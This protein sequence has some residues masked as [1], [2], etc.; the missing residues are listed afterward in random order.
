M[1]WTD[2]PAAL[3]DPD[4]FFCDLEVR[5]AAVT[6]PNSPAFAIAFAPTIS[7][8]VMDGLNTL[9]SSLL[10]PTTRQNGTYMS[11]ASATNF[12]AFTL[13]R[14]QCNKAPPPSPP[15]SLKKQ[16]PAPPAPPTQGQALVTFSGVFI[17]QALGVLAGVF[18]WL[19]EKSV[20]KCSEAI[21]TGC[22]KCLR[23]TALERWFK[24][25]MAKRAAKKKKKKDGAGEG[26][27]EGGDEKQKDAGQLNHQDHDNIAAKVVSR[28]QSVMESGATRK[29]DGGGGG[30]GGFA[31]VVHLATSAAA[32]GGR[33]A[34][35]PVDWGLQPQDQVRMLR[36]LVQ[37]MERDLEGGDRGGKEEEDHLDNAG[38]VLSKPQGWRERMR[39]P[40]NPPSGVG[41]GGG[42]EEGALVRLLKPD[43][44]TGE[45]RGEQVGRVAMLR[46]VRT[47]S[48]GR[49]NG[50]SDGE[51]PPTG[52]ASTAVQKLA[53]EP[54]APWTEAERAR[55]DQPPPVSPT[56]SQAQQ[57]RQ[58]QLQPQQEGS[59]SDSRDTPTD[60]SPRYSAGVSHPPAFGP[61]GGPQEAQ[62]PGLRRV[63]SNQETRYT[64]SQ[65]AGSSPRAEQSG[66]KPSTAWDVLRNRQ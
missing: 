49:Q 16:P 3:A 2:S 56:F 12:P 53:E 19:F 14:P 43:A 59:R 50:D 22:E 61:G 35:A 54:P 55:I 10:L 62:V 11:M 57:P 34:P 13:S 6:N 17:V 48:S 40:Q 18:L 58:S 46:R 38:E 26:G 47:A 20:T 27:K 32:A 63:P 29:A 45:N 41:N 15:V 28:L 42:H 23:D 21:I 7:Q 39:H 65:P 52:R 36:A 30:G 37:K 60:F 8:A 51:E 9:T 66:A 31:R 4:G 1:D 64:A 25:Y 33:G 44:A 5:G 24:E